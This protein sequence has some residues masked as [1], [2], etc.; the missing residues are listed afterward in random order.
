MKRFEFLLKQREAWGSWVGLLSLR[1]LLGWEFLEAGL[2]KLQ[3]ENWFFEI[4]SQFPIPFN[5]LPATVNWTLATFVEVVGG[6]ALILGLGVRFFAALLGVVTWVA[7]LSVH[8]P[9]HWSTWHE[10]LQGYRFTD[11]GFGS[12]KLP[13]IFLCMLWPLLFLGAGRLSLDYCLHRYFTK[14]SVYGQ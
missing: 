14:K 6:I 8:W 10:L 13:V 7:L 2:E 12:F 3:G 1:L 9:E 11:Q 4:Q 5:L